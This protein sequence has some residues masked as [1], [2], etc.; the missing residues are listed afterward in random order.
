M[1]SL[2][3]GPFSEI[4]RF[5]MLSDGEKRDQVVQVALAHV[6][7]MG[8]TGRIVGCQCMNRVFVQHQETW[9]E[10]LADVLEASLTVPDGDVR[11]RL[12]AECDCVPDLGPAHCHLCGNEK[13]VPVPWPEC[14]AVRAAAPEP[15]EQFSY[16]EK[17]ADG[18]G[19]YERITF[20]SASEAR[21]WIRNRADGLAAFNAEADDEADRLV[22]SVERRTT[23]SPGPWLPLPV[24]GE[25]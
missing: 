12:H 23:Y 11:G 5:L 7:V 8:V 1:F 15:G 9:A 4:R 13:G 16:V 6:P 3:L 2:F 25:S 14:S 10:H 18:S 19:V 20:G 22:A 21:E 24:G 17:W